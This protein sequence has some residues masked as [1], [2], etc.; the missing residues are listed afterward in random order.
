MKA[1]AVLLVVYSVMAVSKVIQKDLVGF[2]CSKKVFACVSR[3]LWVDVLYKREMR[4]HELM[5]SRVDL[6]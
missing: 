2:L 4:S 3:G 5:K 6:V 1:F